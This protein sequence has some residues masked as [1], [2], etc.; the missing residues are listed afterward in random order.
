MVS[1]LD[2]DNAVVGPPPEGRLPLQPHLAATDNADYLSERCE[3]A[4]LLRARPTGREST[5][6][7]I[8][9][10][11]WWSLTDSNR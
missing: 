9:S 4:A 1:V 11:K 5:R 10:G 3:G 2:L 8:M 6:F 7:P